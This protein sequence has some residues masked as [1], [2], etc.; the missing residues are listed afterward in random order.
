MA[1]GQ[2]Q[3]EWVSG[4]V[5]TADPDKLGSTYWNAPHTDADGNYLAPLS[6]GFVSLWAGTIASLPGG[7]L[8]CDGSSL[9]RASYPALFAAIGTVHGAADGTHFSLP[10]LRDKFIVGAKQ[11]DSGVPKTN[12]TGSLTQSGGAVSHHHA[13][14]TLSTNVAISAHSR[15]TDVAI[16]AHANGAV[17]SHSLSTNVALSAH[18]GAAVS[19][20]ANAA[21]SAH[22]LSTNVA[23]A[24]HGTGAVR[25]SNASSVAAATVVSHTITQPVVAA[26]SVTQPDNHSIT[27]PSDHS[28]T[29]PVVSAHSVTQPDAHAITQPVFGDHSITQPVVAA[30]DTLSAPQPY[31]AI[32]YVI[33]TGEAA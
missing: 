21:V 19:A 27:Q 7:W 10:D 4:F 31:Y 3:H 9:L 14:H 29:Q 1:G 32:A 33:A 16:S 5:D 6:A 8:L 20:H 26:H 17:S 12:L 24:S 13:D 11:D 25:T 2:V 30:H 28:I 18:S 15:T 22:S 23:I